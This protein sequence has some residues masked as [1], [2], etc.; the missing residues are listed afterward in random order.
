V[1]H[2]QVFDEP[3]LGRPPAEQLAGLCAGGWLVDREDLPRKPKVSAG[4]GAVA[5]FR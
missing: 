5:T 2:V 1:A 3:G 4:T